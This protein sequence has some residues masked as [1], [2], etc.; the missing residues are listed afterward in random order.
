ML[1]MNTERVTTDDL[2][3]TFVFICVHP[4]FYI[5]NRGGGDCPNGVTGASTENG[6]APLTLRP[7]GV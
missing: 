2:V 7:Y 5:G 4:W 6:E 3:P 1:R